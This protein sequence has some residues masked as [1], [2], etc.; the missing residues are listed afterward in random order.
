MAV[1]CDPN[2]LAVLAACFL[3]SLSWDQRDAIKTYLSCLI[4]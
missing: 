3:D 2:D 1:S 4:T